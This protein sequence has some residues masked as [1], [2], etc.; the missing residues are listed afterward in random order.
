MALWQGR[1]A[2]D[3]F[4]EGAPGAAEVCSWGISHL[5]ALSAENFSKKRRR[6]AVSCGPDPLPELYNQLIMQKRGIVLQQKFLL[7]LVD[8]MRPDGL[9]QCGHEFLPNLTGT[10]SYSLNARTVL[11]SVTLPC[12]CS[13]FFS[14]DPERHGIT[15]NLWMPPV[16]PI[17][18]LID[19]VAKA[20]GKTGSFYNWE[21]LRDLSRPGSLSCSYY[22]GMKGLEGQADDM[23]T[24]R[25]IAY[26][27]D[28]A[29]DFVFLYLGRTDE[30]GHE[31]GWMSE[32]YLRAIHRASACIERITSRLPAEYSFVV[33]AD[34]GGHGRMHGT[35]L[36][37]DMTIPIFFQG[38]DFAPGK[39]L[40]GLGIKDI[41]PTI[42][43]HMGIPLPREWE[44][45]AV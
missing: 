12:H 19:A 31:K 14:V 10:A 1:S 36:P 30:A 17:D 29:P 4:L 40:S 28:Q 3:T 26:I 32:E 37:E 39:E 41:A 16:R 45:R 5:P 9:L 22:I 7:I 43:T 11:P 15:T 38:R 23:V 6:T 44:G 20:G 13:L 27:Q 18:S 24:D 33:T 2:G 8:G 42:L 34:H 21:E 25:A 35:E